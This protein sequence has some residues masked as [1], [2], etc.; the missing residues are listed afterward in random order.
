MGARQAFRTLGLC[1]CVVLLFAIE[2]C[3]PD[4]PP[5]LNAI[6]PASGYPR[7]LLGVDG[8]TSLASVVWDVGPNEQTFTNGWLST[9]YFQ[10]PAN[11]AP[12]VYPVALRTSKGT[13]A[14]KNVT[15]LAS[16]GA[17][18]PPRIEDI[19][20]LAYGDAGQGR[21]D[22]ILI[23]TAANLDIAATVTARLSG[24]QAVP[25]TVQFRWGGLP[26]DFQLTHTPATFGYPVYHYLQQ[27]AI[28]DAVPLGSTLDVTVTNTDNQADTASYV[29]PAAIADF[30]SDG[31]GL[32]DS[33]DG[34]TYTAPSG[35]TI[36]LKALGTGVGRKDVLIEADWI[37]AATPNNTIW[38]TIQQSFAAA[39][40]MNPN[41][42]AGI[43]MIIDHGQGGALSDGGDVLADH[44]T[45]DFGA[46]TAQ[47][48]ANFFDYKNTNFDADRLE[49]F[50]YVVFGR[51]RPN[52]SS[53]RGELPGNDF[54]VTF[55]TFSQWS[56]A[57]AQVGTFIHEF[58]HNLGL[59]HGDLR[60][61]PS[62][63]NDTQKPNFP[64]TMSYRYQFPGV[65]INCD[66][67]SDGIHTY[68]QGTFAQLREATAS[69]AVGI[70]DNA[71]LD[72]NGDG[73][74]TDVGRDFNGD[75]DRLDMST[76]F[77]QW[78]DV[79]LNFRAP[80]SNWGN[81]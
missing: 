12:G 7:Q 61:T 4:R 39:P 51:V 13:S 66:F 53:G 28:V 20:M 59:S 36:D 75:G 69:E 54:M 63:W 57:I 1:L 74:T 56:Q 26:V 58:G 55:S 11:A 3:L 65:S 60:T 37:Q 32:I 14:S 2:G 79:F 41:G 6:A 42:S 45:M 15:V 22:I 9:D 18:P 77:D 43:T 34:K 40:V 70:C 48:Y 64:S 31:D 35:N 16:S 27:L 10:I 5:I 23:V 68:S 8:E 19:G 80:G 49:V 72:F 71:P 47:G 25:V 81:N 50:H 38:A 52:G 67:V 73:D 33:V 76:D 46:S 29:I 21:A 78:G 44:Q 24:G 30:D 17:F 62:E